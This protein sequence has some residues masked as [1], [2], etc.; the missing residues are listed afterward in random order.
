NGAEVAVDGFGR[1]KKPRRGAGAG[2]RGGDLPADQAGLTHARD[3]HAA[4][5]L[6]EEL[7]GLLEVAVDPVDETK[8]RCR[9][10]AENLAGEFQAGQRVGQ[11]AAARAM[12]CMRASRVS[13]GSSNDSRSAF[14]AS[15]F[16]CSGRSW[17]SMNIPS[18]PAA[19]PAE[20][21]GSM[22]CACPAVTPLPAPG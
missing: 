10:D 12:A 20:A 18:T 1:M 19:T 3:D 6:E 5:A 4:L 22:N 14:C 7:D 21:S 17:T 11:T 2:E 13:S 8:D 16:A 9:F 15:L